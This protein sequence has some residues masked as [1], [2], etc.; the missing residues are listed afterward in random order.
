MSTVNIYNRNFGGREYFKTLNNEEKRSKIIDEV[1]KIILD[2]LYEMYFED[3]TE[4]SYVVII[5]DVNE[6]ILRVSVNLDERLY[7]KLIGK[8]IEEAKKKELDRVYKLITNKILSVVFDKL[9]P[10]I[11]GARIFEGPLHKMIGKLLCE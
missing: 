8:L 7:N 5:W 10:K 2:T 1:Y 6:S 11:D 9:K 3:V 4:H